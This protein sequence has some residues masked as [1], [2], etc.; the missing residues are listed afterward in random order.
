MCDYS[1]SWVD[2]DTDHDADTGNFKDFYYCRTGQFY[3]LLSDNNFVPSAA[4]AK[5]CRLRV[6]LVILKNDLLI[7]FDTTANNSMAQ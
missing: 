2:S 5:V 6:L 7:P 4:L 1:N 3:S